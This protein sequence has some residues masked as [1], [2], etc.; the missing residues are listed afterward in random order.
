MFIQFL[1]LLIPILIIPYLIETIGTNFYA[2]YV[3]LLTS[4]AFIS[5]FNDF[6]I[7]VY[8]PAAIAKR[9]KNNLALSFFVGEVFQLKAILFII[10]IIFSYLLLK[11]LELSNYLF[12][13]LLILFGRS[14]QF[15]WYFQ[16]IQKLFFFGITNTL[17][18]LVFLF[19]VLNNI[20]SL[21]DFSLLLLFNGISQ[22]SISF[23]TLLIIL[24]RGDLVFVFSFVKIY[25]LVKR[26]VTFFTSRFFLNL[27]VTLNIIILSKFS[28]NLNIVIYSLVE[29]IYNVLKILFSQINNSFLP[30]MIKNKNIFIF[31]SFLK[32]ILFLII[33]TISLLNIF[34]NYISFYFLNESTL[35]FTYLIKIF[36][37]T[38]FFNVIS[39]FIG[40]PFF[41]SFNDNKTPNMSII[42]GGLLFLFGLCILISFDLV[43]IYSISYNLFITEL[44]IF[45]YRFYFYRLII[46]KN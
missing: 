41:L 23:I 43:T 32:I 24:K 6:G 16:G 31:Q 19:L 11:Y 44:F 42:F 28:S 18:Q 30:Y 3:I 39:A 20:N 8:G 37:I 13:F 21:Y 34:E 35:I 2:D 17:S 26:L 4:I 46:L 14:F 12:L 7:S 22:I 38:L 33:I 25:K 1:N 45:I 40:Y 15:L 29:Q 9:K 36:S 5:F 27:I 10:S